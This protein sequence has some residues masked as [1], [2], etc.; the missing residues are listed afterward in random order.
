MK[1]LSITGHSLKTH[2][3]RGSGAIM[4]GKD[5]GEVGLAKGQGKLRSTSSQVRGNKKSR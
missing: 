4:Q 2:Y 1:H 5:L 3:G